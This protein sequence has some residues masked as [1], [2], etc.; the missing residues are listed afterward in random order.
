MNLNFKK[1]K[2]PLS[3]RRKSSSVGSGYFNLYVERELCRQAF[4]AFDTKETG[5]IPKKVTSIKAGTTIFLWNG[6]LL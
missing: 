5:G 1:W 6:Y 2:L 4:E 3:S